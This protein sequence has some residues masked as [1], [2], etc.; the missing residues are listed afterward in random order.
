[1]IRQCVQCGA[2]C[3]FAPCGYGESKT[4]SNGCKYLI[5]QEKNTDYEFFRCDRYEYII[6]QKDAAI[7]PAFGSGCCMSLFNERRT[8]N[9]HAI[10]YRR[11][12]MCNSI[13]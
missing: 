7:S 11:A 3:D 6:T 5:S 2:C 8:K 10:E 12:N 9:I 1:M 4:N 13:D